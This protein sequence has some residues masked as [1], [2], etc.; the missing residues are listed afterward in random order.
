MRPSAEL[1][2]IV[3]VLFLSSASIAQVEHT[4]VPN[5]VGGVSFWFN[6]MSW[7]TGPLFDR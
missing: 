2:S 5:P 1:A 6:P 3:S 7:D 4:F